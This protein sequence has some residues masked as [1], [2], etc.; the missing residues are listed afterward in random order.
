VIYP[1]NGIF[2]SIKKEMNYYETMKKYR[3]NLMHINKGKKPLCKSYMLY[4]STNK[5]YFKSQKYTDC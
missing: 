1:H 5:K 4:D 3:G 2:S